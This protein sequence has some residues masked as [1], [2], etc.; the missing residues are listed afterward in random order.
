MRSLEIN[1]TDK[2][3]ESLIIAC[4]NAREHIFKRGK[5][6]FINCVDHPAYKQ[7]ICKQCFD[8]EMER[9]FKNAQT[10]SFEL[11]ELKYED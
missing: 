10:V 1:L 3:G 9:N 11:P 6:K 5:G 8:E 4:K 7:M 2:G